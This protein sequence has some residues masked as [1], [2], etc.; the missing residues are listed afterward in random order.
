MEGIWG[1]KTEYKKYSDKGIKLFEDTISNVKKE[2]KKEYSH[3]LSQDPRHVQ[4]YDGVRFGC[5]DQLVWVLQSNVSEEDFLK[6]SKHYL[7]RV[8]LGACETD[9]YYR[10]EKDWG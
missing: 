10:F 1:K 3:V 4:L 2:F 6:D 9:Y 8:L 5:N 7:F